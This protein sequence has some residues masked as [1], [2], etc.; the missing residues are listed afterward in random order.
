MNQAKSD[1]EII[2]VTCASA[3]SLI[4]FL[5]GQLVYRSHYFFSLDK[6]IMIKFL[7]TINYH[8]NG[9]NS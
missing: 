1:N 2:I 8:L 9:L 7:I 6:H 3:G 5:D 4:N